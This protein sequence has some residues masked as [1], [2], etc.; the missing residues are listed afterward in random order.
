M[1]NIYKNHAAFG[2]AKEKGQNMKTLH[3]HIGTPKTASTSIQIFCKE[4]A[5]LL[6]KQGYCYPILPFYYPGIAPVHNAHFLVGALKGE[7]KKEKERQIFQEGMQK[8]RALFQKYD[9]VILSDEAVWR[10]VDWY[11]PDLWKDLKQEADQG[12]FSIHIIVYLRR[13]DQFVSSCWNQIVKQRTFQ[14]T[15]EEYRAKPERIVRL[16]YY[17]KLEKIAQ[18]IGKEQITVR[19]FEPGKFVGGDVYTDFLSAL[20]LPMTN[21]YHA[22]QEVRNTGLTGNSHEIKRLLNVF[23]E[24]KDI[25]VR[26]FFLDAL[27]ECMEYTDSE[28]RYSMLSE[29][30]IAE[31]LE[32]YGTG[33]R[34]VAAEYLHEPGAELFDNTIKELP[35]WQKDNPY[36]TDDVIRF[37]GAMGISL[38]QENQ[39]LKQEIQELKDFAR[40][41]RH[42]LRTLW[43]RIKRMFGSGK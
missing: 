40:H 28:Y 23:P 12:G 1:R 11:K 14:D 17:A 18:Y 8:V 31:L 25:K 30:E 33:N 4:N 16:D 37:V 9:H 24:M 35:K 15:F 20:G 34:K 19:R 26:N 22:S 32:R 43:R 7:D 27:R 6:E 41:V 2:R 42:P 29:K 21:E 39:E 3:L 5:Q 10:S 13:Q 38:Y 36:M